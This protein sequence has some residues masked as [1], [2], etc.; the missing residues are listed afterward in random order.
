MDDW[1]N[2][3]NVS[4]HTDKA[5]L[6]VKNEYYNDTLPHMLKNDPKKFGSTVNPEKS[7]SVPTLCGEDGNTLS[8]D[9]CAEKQ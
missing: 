2:Y 5:T 8:L 9:S 3:K 4:N 1:Q 6:E 7:N